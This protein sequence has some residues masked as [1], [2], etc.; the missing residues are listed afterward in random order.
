MKVVEVR[1]IFEFLNKLKL[2]KFDKET[3]IAVLKNYTELFSLYKEQEV[4]MEELRKKIFSSEDLQL[5]Q[6][7][8]NNRKPLTKDL[9]EKNSEYNSVIA[10]LFNEDINL[11]L[12]KVDKDKFLDALSETDIEYTPMDIVQLELLFK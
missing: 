1:T 11:E 6:D 7:S 3:R 10:A 5:L 2:N 8:I 9:I 12:L 4:K